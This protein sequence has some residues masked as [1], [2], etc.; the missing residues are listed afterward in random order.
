MKPSLPRGTSP[1]PRHTAGSGFPPVLL[2]EL[3]V[4]PAFT[5][6]AEGAR[7]REPAVTGPPAPGG[8][9][10]KAGGGAPAAGDALPGA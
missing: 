2:G 4:A 7:R 8:G 10:A 3:V 6:Q 5:A 1:R 9:R